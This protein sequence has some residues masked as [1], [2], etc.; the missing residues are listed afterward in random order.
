MDSTLS[1]D[2]LATFSGV[3]PADGSANHTTSGGSQGGSQARIAPPYSYSSAI[4]SARTASRIPN[5]SS[6]VVPVTYRPYTE[7]D[8]GVADNPWGPASGS[9]TGSVNSS[10]TSS[11]FPFNSN[12]FVTNQQLFQPQYEQGNTQT[13]FDELMSPFGSQTYAPTSYSLPLNTFWGADI[14]SED[15]GDRGE[16]TGFTV[17]PG[18]AVSYSGSFIDGSTGSPEMPD[19]SDINFNGTAGLANYASASVSSAPPSPVKSGHDHDKKRVKQSEP[20]VNAAVVSREDSLSTSASASAGRGGKGKQAKRELRSA[21]R[22]SKNTQERVTE[23]TQ[24]H[25]SR[26]SH[27]MVEKQYRNRLNSQFEGLLHSLPGTARSGKSA[28]ELEDGVAHSE[29]GEGGTASEKRVSKAEVLDMA[30]RHIKSL[31]EETACLRNER[32]D[33]RQSLDRL[34]ESYAEELASEGRS[35]D[36]DDIQPFPG[37]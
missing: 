18:S 31:E 33:L 21:S 4:S 29:V 35:L 22:T 16:M 3:E 26:N 2:G 24:E 1:P 5:N 20:G 10:D 17:S 37:R 19:G 7:L 12:N 28:A 13:S 11:G 25:K 8:T 34:R 9:G 30:R 23:T 15:V 36:S 32:D 27:N 14:G 6:S